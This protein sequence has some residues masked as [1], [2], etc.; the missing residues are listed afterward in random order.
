MTISSERIKQI[1]DAGRARSL[2]VVSLDYDDGLLPKAQLILWY[3]LGGYDDN[4][5]KIYD[6]SGFGLHTEV[7]A[8]QHK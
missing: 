1:H 7:Y 5:H 3:R 4:E 2:E 8:S 6:Q